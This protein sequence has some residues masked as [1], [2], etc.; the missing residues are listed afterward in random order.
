MLIKAI[1]GVA[2]A[3]CPVTVALPEVVGVIA[4]V[5]GGRFSAKDFR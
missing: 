1:N 4:E 3:V 5:V 2:P